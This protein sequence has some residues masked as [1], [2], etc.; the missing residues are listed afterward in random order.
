[1]RSEESGTGGEALGFH[2]DRIVIIH[3]MNNRHKDNSGNKR[4]MRPGTHVKSAVRKSH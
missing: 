2:G 4:S 3:G 1:M